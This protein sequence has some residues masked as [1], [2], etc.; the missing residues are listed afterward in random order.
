MKH[1]EA[2]IQRA[3][4]QLLRTHGIFCWHTPNSGKR[5]M[6]EAVRF[7]QQGVLS[8]IPD[9]CIVFQGKFY[10]LELKAKG[11]RSTD[12]QIQCRNAINIAGGFAAE[13]VGVDEAIA[14]IKVWG[15]V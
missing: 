14:Q 3:V 10:A 12:N 1:P 6:L 15:M 4:I 7:K 5:G 2:A 13:A 8:G 11:G 9:V